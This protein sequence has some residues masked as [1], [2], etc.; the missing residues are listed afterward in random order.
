MAAIYVILKSSDL[1]VD[2]ASSLG[3][4]LSLSD[5]FIGSFIVGIG[6]SLPELFTSI[7]AV[8][9][10][11]P[12]LV[13]P[14]IYGTIVANIAAGFGLGTLALYFVVRTQGRRRFFV[15][16]N[17]IADG[18]LRF[19]N[20]TVQKRFLGAPI[21]FATA[22]VLL[23][24]LF[25]ALG[26]FG[27]WHAVLFLVLYGVFLTF[28]LKRKSI[29]YGLP[30]A[31]ADAPKVTIAVKGGAS[32]WPMAWG[33]VKALAPLL[34]AYF[35]FLYIALVHGV[36][37]HLEVFRA[38]KGAEVLFLAGLG[39]ITGVLVFLAFRWQR[40]APALDFGSFMGAK[41]DKAPRSFLVGLLGVTVVVIYYAG[42][43][44]VEAVE[45]TSAQFG[46]GDT[47]LAASALAVGTSLPDIVV[48]LKVA[49]AGR[50][51]LLFGHIL[52]SNTF[53]VFLVMGI[54]GVMNPLIT[55]QSFE[56]GLSIGVS[57]LFTLALVPVIWMRRFTPLP[58]AVMILAFILFMATL[59]A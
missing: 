32:G 29:G 17:P 57:V 59:Y 3:H 25:Y 9:S 16:K 36:D 5:Y 58:A 21:A 10:N 41:F 8:S 1:L 14:T 31:A 35:L 52:Q 11:V 33:L 44:I 27:L 19:G 13:V 6:T 24:A 38:N 54:C 30:D 51:L 37:E 46:V 43:A 34:L 12:Q 39:I 15:W 4:K 2:A 49:R 40:R 47:V 18:I 28:E 23:T 48:A 50:H 45:W 55:S 56:A 22:S 26:Y 53:D 20:K 42:V 7:A